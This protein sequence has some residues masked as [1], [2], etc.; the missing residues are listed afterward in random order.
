MS[1]RCTVL[2]AFVVQ[3]QLLFLCGI[4][5]GQIFNLAAA[6]ENTQALVITG[7]PAS[8]SV[9]TA[10]VMAPPGSAVSFLFATATADFLIAGVRVQILPASVFL[11]ITVGVDS[12]GIAVIS[13][14]LA[15][16]AP[17]TFIA[18][19]ACIV[20]SD[21]TLQF[22]NRSDLVIVLDEM[23][24]LFPGSVAAAGNDPF[25]VAIADLNGDGLLD[26]AVANFFSDN[27]SVLL[28]QQ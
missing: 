18:C 27:V 19:Q 23:G 13:G 5:H 20:E 28:N 17:G 9:L 8:G 11:I 10:S 2:A 3:L 14:P 26:L 16:A 7:T 21:G 4:M 25:S 22:T 15:A 24:P 1:R 12:T 6:P